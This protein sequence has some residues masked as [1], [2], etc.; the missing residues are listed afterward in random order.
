MLQS[1]VA[2]IG[3]T[4]DTSLLLKSAACKLII[5]VNKKVNY[6]EELK[7]GPYVLPNSGTEFVQ[8]IYPGSFLPEIV[9]EMFLR[10]Q[11]FFLLFHS[12]LH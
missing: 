1:A 11:Y 7:S 10:G 4:Q 5:P 3:H 2:V 9:Y 8:H 12:M 6:E